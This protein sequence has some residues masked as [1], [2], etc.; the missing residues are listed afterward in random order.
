MSSKKSIKLDQINRKIITIVHT[1]ADIS[2]QELSE[3]V[4]LSNS[5][6]FQRTKAL[7][8][9]GYFNGFYTDLDL[10]RIAKNVLAYIEFTLESNNPKAR[11]R[12]EEAINEIPEFMDCLRI[13]GDID[14]ICFTCCSDTQKLNEIC[15][16]VNGNPK[17]GIQKLKTS[18]IL[19]RAKW[20]LGYP[21]QK[22]EWLE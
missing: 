17:L 6:C 9:A 5:A 21:L 7:K 3:R 15:D 10:N 1:Q 16:T 18:I 20:Y 22:L 8:E 13:T 12:F 2:N 11:Q 4:G 19:E 14:Y